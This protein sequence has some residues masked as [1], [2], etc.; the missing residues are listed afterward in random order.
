MKWDKLKKVFHLKII[1]KMEFTKSIGIDVSKDYLDFAL[2]QNH[3]STYLGRIANETEIIQTY[4]EELK[5][6]F[7]FQSTLFCLETT[8]IYTQHF[9]IAAMQMEAKVWLQSALQINQS[10]GIKRGKDDILDA[11]S[12]AEYAFR[13]QDKVKLYEAP[14]ELHE[15]IKALLSLRERLLESLKRLQV[16]LKESKKF[17]AASVVQLLEKHTQQSIEAI[18]NDLKQIQK[19]LFILL[20]KDEQLKKNY[21]LTQSVVGVGKWT[22]L[23]VLITTQNFTKF[24]YAKPYAAYCGVVPFAKS[25]GKKKGKNRISP[26]ANKKMKTLLHMCAL[27]AIKNDEEIKA[28]Y[29]RKVKEGKPKRAVINAIRNKI[30]LRIFAVIKNQKKYE[31]KTVKNLQSS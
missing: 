12:I 28:Y 29:E 6:R 3:Q 10:M 25:S 9:L 14:L 8:G 31:K 22:T 24:T 4:L 21:E 7:D 2:Y 26:L 30:I 15:Q 11:Q 1:Q 20:G 19:E 13:Q 16:P 17:A 18:K 27:S 23:Q 5:R